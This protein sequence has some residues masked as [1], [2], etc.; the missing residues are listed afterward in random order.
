[1]KPNHRTGLLS[2]AV[3]SALA[4]TS[5]PLW[6]QDDD[7]YL[8]EIV[9]TGTR[10]EGTSPLEALSP[11]DVLTGE[12]LAI[13]HPTIRSYLSMARVDTARRWSTCRSRRLVR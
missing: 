5:T 9:T 6:A 2:F 7:T 10:K 11:V 13:S 1:M 4:I 12:A 3:A 8:D